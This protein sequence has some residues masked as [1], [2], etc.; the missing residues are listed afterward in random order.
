VAVGARVEHTAGRSDDEG[1]RLIADGVRQEFAALRAALEG[2]RRR[3]RPF[4]DRSRAERQ[5]A[6]RGLFAESRPSA[7][8]ASR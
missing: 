4:A 1:R 3:F 6:A 5:A 2:C 7:A 8:R